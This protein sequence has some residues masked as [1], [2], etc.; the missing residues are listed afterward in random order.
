MAVL[1]VVPVRSA[2][3]RRTFLTFPWKIYGS[4]PLWVPPLCSERANA[5]DPEKG[6]FFKRGVA[7][8]F[9]A[10]SGGKAVGTI[11]AAE[12]RALNRRLGKRECVFGFFECLND[13]EVAKALLDRAA[14]WARDKA[15]DTLS[16]PFNLDYED[17]Y[18]VLVEGRD[19]PPALLC[20]HTPPYYQGFLERHGFSPL[21]GDNT[22]YE[23][24]LTEASPACGASRSWRTE[25]DDR[26]G[27]RSGPPT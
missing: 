22:A 4:D 13:Y 11:S 23:I 14:R 3:E 24:S 8:L 16:G 19:R 26:V 27:S 18:G 10:W 6:A 9:V 1:E 12:D 25:S 7:E 15:L 20:G 5:V 2:R 17:S 21:R